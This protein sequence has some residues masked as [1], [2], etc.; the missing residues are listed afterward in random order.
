MSL[1]WLSYAGEEGS[2]GVVVVEGEDFF[3]AVERSKVLGLSPGGQVR[4]FVV[5]AEWTQR[6]LPLKDALWSREQ[7]E[8]RGFT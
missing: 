3:S 4:G 7:L 6:C 8:E 5:P 1:W 2:R